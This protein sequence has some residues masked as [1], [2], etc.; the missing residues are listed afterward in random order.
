MLQL[1]IFIG[2]EYWG[3]TT[4]RANMTVTF[5]IFIGLVLGRC[6]FKGMVKCRALDDAFYDRLYGVPVFTIFFCVVL[7][8][9]VGGL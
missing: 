1:S 3:T 7:F 5:T 8:R 9:G 2:V 6:L 4:T